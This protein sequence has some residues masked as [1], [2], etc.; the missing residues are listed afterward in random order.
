[1]QYSRL[2]VGNIN[3]QAS[4]TDLKDL[5]SQYGDVKSVQLIERDGLKKGFGFVEYHSGNDAS[6]A[7][8]ELDGKEFMTRELRVDFAKPREPRF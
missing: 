3:Y 6:S 2:Y 1:M 8:E 5:F 7:K 4:E